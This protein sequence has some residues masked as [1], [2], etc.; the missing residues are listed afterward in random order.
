MT[1]PTQQSVDV[2]G[3]GV[4]SNVRP[5]P[6]LQGYDL[7]YH[8]FLPRDSVWTR[9]HD[10]Y[11]RRAVQL[12]T[13]TKPRRVVEVGCGDG[14]NCHQLV[15]A[16]IAVT[17]VDWSKKGIALATILVPDGVFAVGDLTDSEFRTRLSPPFD[18]ALV[19]EVIEHIRPE[20]CPTRFAQSRS[21]FGQEV[22]LS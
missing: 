2:L 5:D 12:V 3:G 17:G 14:W 9:I 20:E 15:K 19:V 6:E 11:V 16:G 13:E 8:W 1:S 7:P 18:V 22:P 4:D 21:A 10:A